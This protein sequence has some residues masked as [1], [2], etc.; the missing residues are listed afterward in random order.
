MSL[1]LAAIAQN[2]RR[3]AFLRREQEL[4]AAHPASRGRVGGPLRERDRE[5]QADDHRRHP[6]EQRE[7]HLVCGECEQEP[8]RRVP[9][10][11]AYR[12][13][14]RQATVIA[15]LGVPAAVASTHDLDHRCRLD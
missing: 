13:A 7:R 10:V 2:L 15:P 5:N 1:F 8:E 11:A 4:A 14:K 3:F 9:A 6:G 12:G